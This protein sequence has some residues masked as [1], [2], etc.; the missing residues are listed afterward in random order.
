MFHVLRNYPS[1]FTCKGNRYFAVSLELQRCFLSQTASFR[2]Q[3]SNFFG[4]GWWG[5]RFLLSCPY[6][7]SLRL[8]L[9]QRQFFFAVIVKL[10]MHVC[11]SYR[12]WVFELCTVSLT[13]SVFFLKFYGGLIL[14][15]VHFFLA[16]SHLYLPTLKI[17]TEAVSF[18]HERGSRVF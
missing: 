9:L 3:S 16:I 11:F 7:T 4:F 18:R 12:K 5:P 2:N 15:K 13:E 14:I 8:P 17:G 1:K 6:L 10:L